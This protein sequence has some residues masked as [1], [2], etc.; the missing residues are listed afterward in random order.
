MSSKEILV[1]GSLHYDI[2]VE[3]TNLPKVG[4][5]VRGNNWY[6]KLGGKGGNQ[7]ISAS[8]NSVSVK[9]N[10]SDDAFITI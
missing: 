4:E 9:L 3:S 2:F 1:I 8:L 10:L 7:A 5:T 6:P